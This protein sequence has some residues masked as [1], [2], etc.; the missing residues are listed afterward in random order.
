MIVENIARQQDKGWRL[1]LSCGRK[2]ASILLG[3]QD[4]R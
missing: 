4:W 3:L 1:V 2:G